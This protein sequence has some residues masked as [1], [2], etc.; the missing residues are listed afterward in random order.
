MK[1]MMIIIYTMD[2]FFNAVQNWTEKKLT[3]RKAR[4]QYKKEHK[5]FLSEVLSWLDALAFAVVVVFLVNQFIF[6]L[7]VIPSPSMEDTLLVGDRVVV[8]KM[9]YGIEVYPYGPKIFDHRTPDRDDIIT[10]YNPEYESKGTAYSILSRVLYM[11]TFGLWNIEVDEDGN[12]GEWLFVKRTAALAGDTVTFKNGQ[13]YIKVRGTDTYV[14]EASFREEN[15]YVSNPKRLIESQ[16]YP[17]Y[18]A[19]G[20][21]VGI[22]EV[23]NTTSNM[24]KHLVK[25]YQ[26]LDQKAFF[27]D[28]YGY[29]KM[30]LEGKRMA[31]PTDLEARSE[32]TKKNIGLFVPEG[33]VLPLGDNRDNSTDGRYFGPVKIST[34]TGFVVSRFWP[35]SRIKSLVNR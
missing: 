22:S 30:C 16:T 20:R 32:W 4:N 17:S 1:Q 29:D 18:N 19:Q 3:L 15:R 10:F 14:N 7:F 13:A 26:N 21:I 33:Y 28:Y 25:D 31:D 11:A 6:Q 24:P 27:T 12:P 34:I 23:T 5:T 35:L 2:T 8:S 9:T